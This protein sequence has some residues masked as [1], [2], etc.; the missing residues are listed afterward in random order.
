MLDASVDL[1][2]NREQVHVTGHNYGI[3]PASKYPFAPSLM[4]KYLYIACF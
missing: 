4:V 2:D 1:A 3:M